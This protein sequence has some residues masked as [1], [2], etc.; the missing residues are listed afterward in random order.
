MRFANPVNTE[1]NHRRFYMTLLATMQRINHPYPY[2]YLFIH[3]FVNIF[4]V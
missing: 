4:Y 1:G 3:L 2:S